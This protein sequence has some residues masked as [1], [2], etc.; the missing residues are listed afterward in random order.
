MICPTCGS[1]HCDRDA[2]DIGV[3]TQYGPWSCSE[4]GWVEWA[5]RV[6]ERNVFH[7]HLDAC[8]QC[9]EHPFDLCADGAALLR[10]AAL[11]GS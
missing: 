3:G 2:V 10:I 4:C 8:E 5:G 1:S 7:V 11:A 6:A 9:R